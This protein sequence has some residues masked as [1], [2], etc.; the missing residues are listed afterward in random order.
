LRKRKRDLS[1][2]L[3][4][5][6]ASRGV[7]TLRNLKRNVLSVGIILER[8]VVLKD[9]V[10][11]VEPVT[12]YYLNNGRKRRYGYLEMK[13]EVNL[14]FKRELLRFLEE[15]GYLEKP[16]TPE[17]RSFIKVLQDW[18]PTT[19]PPIR[20]I[21]STFEELAGIKVASNI[22]DLCQEI[23]TESSKDLTTLVR[24]ASFLLGVQIAQGGSSGG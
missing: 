2:N 13:E 20:Y 16:P 24:E 7:P 19:T 9:M 17:I 1:M 18:D 8:F 11:F 12:M 4:V 3:E 21:M 23:A 15:K 22:S 14:S 5:K 10:S 6:N